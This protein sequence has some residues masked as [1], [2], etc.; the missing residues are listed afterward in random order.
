[1]A[2]KRGTRT[3]VEAVSWGPER[4]RAMAATLLRSKVR[5]Y[6]KTLRE[7]AKQHDVE[8]EIKMSDAV[9]DALAAEAF[10]HAQAIARTRNEAALRIAVKLARTGMDDKRL[11]SDLRQLIE[12]RQR[13]RTPMIAVTE[14]Y[15]PHADATLGFYQ[16]AP[17]AF[18]QMNFGGRPDLGDSPA[19]CE[20]CQAIIAGNPWSVEQAIRIGTPHPQCRQS[21]HS[22]LGGPLPDSMVVGEEIAGIVGSESLVLRLGSHADAAE[23][24]RS[25]SV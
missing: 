25:R 6:R 15:G 14:A 10:N 9:K 11:A 8:V 17:D 4:V 22:E 1:M 23:A 5:V 12:Q 16:Q 21:W 19:E 20:V 7:L 24:I 2:T 18:P 13:K 3:A